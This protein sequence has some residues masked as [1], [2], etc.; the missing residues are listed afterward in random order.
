MQRERVDGPARGLFEDTLSTMSSPRT[1][2]PAGAPAATTLV[3]LP[4]LD[5]PITTPDGAFAPTMAADSAPPSPSPSFL[6]DS[7]ITGRYSIASSLGQGGMG[8]VRLAT[9]RRIGREVAIKTMHPSGA[10]RQLGARFLREACVQGQLEH[11]AVVPV[12]DLGRDS[13]GALYFTMRRVR[14][15]TFGEIIDRLRGGDADAARQYSRRKLISAFASVCQAVHFAHTRGVVHRDLKPANVMLGDFGEV[16]VLDW[17]VAKLVNLPDANFAGERPSVTAAS[18]PDARTLAGAAMGTPG[19]MAPEQARG[20]EDVDRRADVYALGAVLFEL[21]C[22]EPLHPAKTFEAI[23]LSTVN[24][25]DAR[26]S[27][28]APHA[29][30]PPELEAI[31]VKATAVDPADR[32]PDVGELLDALERFLDGDRDLDQRRRAAQAHAALAAAAAEDALGQSADATG[33]RQRALLEVGRALALDP[34]NPD[35]MGVLVR[36]LTEPPRELP[37]EALAEMRAQGKNT[38]HAAAKGALYGYLAWFVFLPFRYWMG[39]RDPRLATLASALWVAAAVSSFL[40]FR[41]GSQRL[42]PGIVTTAA[43][44]CVT[45]AVCGPYVLVPTLAVINVILWLLYCDRAERPTIIVLGGLTV[46]VPATMEWAGVLHFYNFRDGRVTILQGMLD[47]PPAATHAFLLVTSLMLVG[48]AAAL[49]TRFRDHLTDAERRL[50][51]QAWQ[52][53]QL[54]PRAPDPETTRERSGSTS[55]HP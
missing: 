36:L 10:S 7:T 39:I 4:V 8:V 41:H 54:V 31:C 21:L 37:A 30:I 18:T 16:Y 3:I 25:A 55:R 44:A 48:I 20:V 52:L 53:R 47:F 42:W 9:D 17:G 12:H 11:P 35:S 5:A 1:P 22:L 19:Y 15:V 45:S 49:V 23:L 32:F 6:D 27:V 40:A 29:E 33:A 28:R 38:R 34:A 13:D 26:P 43:A 14:G 24:G 51:M 46:L 2:S 50:H